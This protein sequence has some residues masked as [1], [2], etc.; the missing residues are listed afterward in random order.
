MLNT[1]EMNMEVRIIYGLTFGDEDEVKAFFTKHSFTSA[2]DG[3][4]IELAYNGRYVVGIET[5]LDVSATLE[6]KKM[7]EELFP[8][9]EGAV[10]PFA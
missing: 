1:P 7:W 6:A 8:N 2:P 3:I 9:V 4:S 10:C 5:K